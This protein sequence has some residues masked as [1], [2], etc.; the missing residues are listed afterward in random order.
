VQHLL[1][2]PVLLAA[3]QWDLLLA[4][5]PLLQGEELAVRME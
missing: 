5:V 1:L 2:H 3:L 4:L